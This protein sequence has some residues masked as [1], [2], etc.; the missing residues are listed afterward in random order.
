MSSSLRDKKIDVLHDILQE[1]TSIFHILTDP[2]NADFSTA[3]LVNLAV[4][5]EKFPS[6]FFMPKVSRS[7]N[8]CQN[9]I[10]YEKPRAHRPDPGL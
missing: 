4:I 3:I 1:K 9:S 5:A 2:A 7:Q 6:G 8:K 10:W